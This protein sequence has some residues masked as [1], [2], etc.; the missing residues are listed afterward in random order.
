[1]FAAFSK[2]SS[3]KPSDAVKPSK[4]L[5][6]EPPSAESK[7]PE[8][9]ERLLESRQK[10][11]AQRVA[12][13]GSPASA[14]A[15]GSASASGSASISKPK[16]SPLSARALKVK[17]ALRQKVDVDAVVIRPDG[18]LEQIKYNG[19]SKQANEVLNGRPTIIGELESIQTV[20][21]RSLNQSSCGK[22][23]ETVLPV[24]FCNK[25]FNGNYLLYRVDAKGN[26]INLSVAQYE[27][28]VADNKT[29]TEQARKNFNP[30]EAQEIPALPSSF[31]SN[32]RLTLVYLRSEVDKKV[33]AEFEEKNGRKPKEA[34]IEEEV[35]AALQRVV[36]ELVSKSTPMNDPDYNPA[37]DEKSAEED[38]N[39]LRGIQSIY[40]QENGVDL[41]KQDLVATLNKTQSILRTEAP[42]TSA[43][44]GNDAEFVDERDWRLQLNDALNYVRERGRVDGRILADKISETFYELNGIEP[45]M[46][47]LVDVFRRIKNEL[48]LEAQ[49]DYE[50]Q[51]ALEQRERG[52]DAN[53]DGSA[54]YL[55]KKLGRDFSNA[56]PS[57]LVDY[58]F[59]IVKEDLI[60]RAKSSFVISK[61]RSPSQAELQQT[62]EKLALKLANQA[63]KLEETAG[64]DADEEDEDA[65]YDPE[66]TA[67]RRLAQQD[68]LETQQFD[69]DYW[70]L[71]MLTTP[72][73]KSR[74]GAA[75]TYDVYFCRFSKKREARNLER[76]IASFRLRNKREPNAVEIAKIKR[77]I[78]T[79]QN[80]ATNLVQFK[81]S[82]VSDDDVEDAV[83]P[84]DEE[85]KDE[86]V[87]AGGYTRGGRGGVAG[88]APT[89]PSKVLVTPVKKKKT[90]ARYNV[91]FDSA[92][93][94]DED[95]NEKQAMKWFQRFNNRKPTELELAG[96]RQFIKADKS[97]LTE[98]EYEVPVFDG[99]DRKDT[100]EDDKVVG[101]RRM[102]QN[103]VI[104][105]GN[106]ATGY[107][108]DF[109]DER[110]NGDE[111][112]ARKWFQRFNN[113][114]PTASEVDKIRQFIKADNDDTV[115]ID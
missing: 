96:I 44:A 35:E 105:K 80:A 103:S 66:N 70:N 21:V 54:Y 111:K 42:S 6:S 56:D 17:Q 67:D 47:Q 79:S 73:R 48:A 15:A 7:T 33:R 31:N 51:L 86:I 106:K 102:K 18:S 8:N 16:Q 30:V 93:K 68:A 100:E 11:Q 2:K 88:K 20:I 91:Y 29:L 64:A 94:S 50:E 36:D 12:P 87:R 27:K 4:T 74:L 112:A 38:I 60:Y 78:S 49:E 5:T 71:R 55:A 110:E 14:K 39:L 62:V 13:A 9:E 45:T 40:K 34:E 22:K 28:Y 26:P 107:T 72:R 85:E 82:V 83:I 69:D 24:P 1:M 75:E 46:D 52:A 58:A 115:D 25:S 59:R 19:S 98:C 109:K 76:A 32:S 114:K 84:R 37:D 23:N 61:G 77:F 3:P 89:T 81:L 41:S 97:Q 57:D 108:L 113:R 63:L 90:A 10:K 92:S 65:D 101:L 43:A 99:D 95:K 53:D 104:K